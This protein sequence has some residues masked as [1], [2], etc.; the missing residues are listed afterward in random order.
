MEY[1]YDKP[2]S[3][4]AVL[5]MRALRMLGMKARTRKQMLENGFDERPAPVPKPLMRGLTVSDF[6]HLGRKVWRLEKETQGSNTVILYFH[7]GAY[8]A[9]ITGAHWTLAA[10]LAGETGAAVYVPDYPLVPRSVWKD[11]WS[12]SETLYRE[13]AAKHAGARMV[14][15]G[16]SAGGGLA[17]ALAERLRD[18]GEGAPAEVILFSPWLDLG[19]DNPERAVLDPLDLILSLEGLRSAASTG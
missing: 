1:R 5:V 18:S 7:G 15:M 9:N 2:L 13:L 12:F 19:S 16:D 3:F 6:R 4:Q 10:K 8:M 11:T 14:L 17:L